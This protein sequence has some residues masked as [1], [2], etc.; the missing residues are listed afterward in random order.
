M[1]PVPRDRSVP[2]HLLPA[3][4][5]PAEKRT[6]DALADWPW[7]SLDDLAG[8]GGTGRARTR[9]IVAALR[10]LDL[11]GRVPAAGGRLR[12][13]DRGLALPARRDR[14]SVR[15]AVGHWGVRSRRLLADPERT[16]DVRRF[17]ADLAR[18]ARRRGWGSVRIDPPHRAARRLPDGRGTLRPDAFV[19]LGRG[20][21]SRA[22]LLV[23]ARRWVRPATVAARLA[24][25]L[26]YYASHRPVDDHGAVPLVL[27]VCRDEAARVRLL[28]AARDAMARAGVI[29]SLLAAHRFAPED[30]G[31]LGRIW[32]DADGRG[33]LYPLPTP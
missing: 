21:T 4:L 3:L 19:L 1:G 23:W 8:L 2:D 11:V 20:R 24:P 6:L 17:L 16:A 12:L 7:I 5:G 25:Y 13:T 33:P 22:F 10:A 26:R 28:A 31:P 27:A 30:G 14:T 9:E 32:T 15:G 29:V 18:G